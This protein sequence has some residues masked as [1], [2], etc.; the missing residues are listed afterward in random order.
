[1]FAS[2][3]IREMST[4]DLN[5]SKNFIKSIQYN[6]EQLHIYKGPYG[7][8][9]SYNKRFINVSNYLK[10]MNSSID[11][12]NSDDISTIVTYPKKVCTHNKK[13][14][15]IH[16]GPYGYYLKY[17]NK[18]Y[19]INQSIEWSKKYCLSII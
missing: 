7:Y 2:T 9:L 6:N 18:N 14:I 4:I 16:I 17:N 3:V 10:M 19:K 1:M 5:R 8:Y 15:Y 11:T 13:D 12:F